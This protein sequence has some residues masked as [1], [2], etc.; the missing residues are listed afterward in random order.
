M[1][2][3]KFFAP[4]LPLPG[5]L[6]LIISLALFAHLCVVPFANSTESPQPSKEYTLGVFPFLA[7]PTL[8]EIYAPIAAEL[9]VAL[10]RPVR[11][12]IAPSFEKFTENLER[13]HYD[14]AHI[15]PFEYVISGKKSGYKP[16]VTG[17]EMLRAVFAVKAES[18]IKEPHDL[19]GKVIGLP[20]RV[21]TASYLAKVALA[22][23]G[24][25]PDKDVAI[26][27]FRTH[28]SCLQKLLIGDI[29]ACACGE[30]ILH[31]FED[32]SKIKFRVILNSPEIP[33]PLF[34]VHRRVP[35]ADQ[36]T[37]RKALVSSQL[38]GVDPKLRNLF[39]PGTEKQGGYFRSTQDEDFDIVRSYLKMIEKQ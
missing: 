33:Y 4:P 15:H 18:T 6:L 37:I 12:L 8:E 26:Q 23:S 1:Q 16:L 29:D 2:L 13:Q 35:V 9:A 3:D 30:S 5:F 31:V 27:Y 34:V 11:I 17:T 10:G 21:A 22:E 19:K 39:F 20:P 14:I 25:K 7:K 32:Q 28:Q 38:S 36:E 24:L